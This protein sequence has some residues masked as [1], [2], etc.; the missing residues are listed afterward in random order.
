MGGPKDS[1]QQQVAVGVGALAGSTIMLLTFP[2][3]L[4]I[5]AGRVS[6][7]KRG[8]CTYQRPKSQSKGTW[9]KLDP[10]DG[11]K[12]TKSGIEPSRAVGAAAGI[13][14]ATA[15][16]YLLVQ[17]PAF[18]NPS[19]PQGVIDALLVQQDAP[20][21]LVGFMYC[22]L[23]F[24]VYLVY[25]VWQS[26]TSQFQQ[27]KIL[28]AKRKAIESSL[29]S[30]TGAFGSEL[31]EL[32]DRLRANTDP[33][34]QVL[35]PGGR[36]FAF[37]ELLRGFFQRYDINGDGTIDRVEMKG[38]LDALKVKVSDQQLISMME[39]MDINRDGRVDF[40]EFAQCL[41]ELVAS[42]VEG[43]H[44]KHAHGPGQQPKVQSEESIQRLAS[45]RAL[46]DNDE[47]ASQEEEDVPADLADLPPDQQRRRV[48][49]RSL[50]LMGMGTALV[51][52]FSDPMVAVLNELGEN[53]LKVGSFYVSFILAPLASN[54]SE[55]IASFSYAQKKTRRSCT[56]A[57]QTLLGAAVM[58]NTLCLGVFLALVRFR[59]LPWVYTAETLSILMVELSICALVLL[60]RIQRLSHA[61]F[62]ASLYPLS[63]AVVY[64]LE[65]V[66]GWD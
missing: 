45:A 10:A 43:D 50:W 17:F 57:L 44:S 7:D 56:I 5:V 38:V 14:L 36:N 63:L 58:N 53:R 54:A 3:V 55:V 32:S 13:V 6:I 26:S 28:G 59:G 23:A 47:I 42:G 4:T 11:W 41:T 12:L 39:Q 33:E 2:W 51:L 19:A 9:S 48:L 27:E 21:A 64:L 16:A 20:F 52:I 35:L 15:A 65:H 25:S 61:I 31:A 62:V 37:E 1:V 34:A 24:I 22:F 49:Q 40:E 46:M 60:C 8:N 18:R 66:V 30:L 29:V